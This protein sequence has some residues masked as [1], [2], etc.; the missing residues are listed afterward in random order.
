MTCFIIFF[1]RSKNIF[2]L[3]R[4]HARD[5][6][7]EH[8]LKFVRSE[9]NSLNLYWKQKQNKHTKLCNLSGPGVLSDS[10][11]QFIVTRYSRSK[12]AKS[13]LFA[14]TFTSVATEYYLARFEKSVI[15]HHRFIHI[16]QTY[17][18]IKI[19][20]YDTRQDIM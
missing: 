15:V 4:V 19:K 7:T 5:E 6:K 8:K 13:H 14:K 10:N 18:C 16:M 3:F 17:G 12:F 1:P 11:A 2:P 9:G 20:Y